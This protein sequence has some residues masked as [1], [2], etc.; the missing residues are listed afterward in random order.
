MVR[1]K[2]WMFSALT[3]QTRG[4]A[5]QKETVRATKVAQYIPGTYGTCHSKGVGEAGHVPAGLG[6]SF[7]LHDLVKPSL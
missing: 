1:R 5:F 4:G 2:H 7:L 6:Q 3:G